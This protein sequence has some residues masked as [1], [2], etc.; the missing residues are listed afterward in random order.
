[1]RDCFPRTSH[2]KVFNSFRL[3]LGCSTEV[4]S[5]L[6]KLMTFER[7]LPQGAPTS[8][9]LANLTLLGLHDAVGEFAKEHGFS[10]SFYVDDVVI[11][12][13][14]C[15]G[16]IEEIIRFIQK[17][18]HAIKRS[19]I[20]IMPAHV[21]QRITGLVVN[22]KVSLPKEYLETTRKQIIDLSNMEKIPPR[23]LVSVWGKIK[24]IRRACFVRG[25]S[26]ER[27]AKEILPRPPK[28]FSKVKN[29]EYRPCNN[30]RRHLYRIP[31][32]GIY[33]K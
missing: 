27:L 28:K 14:G 10:W 2:V 16:Y 4:S 26:I 13:P 1:M 29:N 5:I 19:K 32:Y 15:E 21:C 17:A 9:T 22:A 7:R 31:K 23:A 6:T 30:T 11:S 8:S 20:K 25:L 12:G 18:G 3:I 24:H 33:G